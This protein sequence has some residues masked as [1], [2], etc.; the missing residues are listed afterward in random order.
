MKAVLIIWL[1][2]VLIIAVIYHLKLYSNNIWSSV[3]PMVL[4]IFTPQLSHCL[5][6]I[7]GFKLEGED[8]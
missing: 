5:S 7:A 1:F 2:T 4:T 6:W 3:S 8:L